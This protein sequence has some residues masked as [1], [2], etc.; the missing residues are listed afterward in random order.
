MRRAKADAAV[1][2]ESAE[3]GEKG[4]IA[5]PDLDHL[6]VTHAVALDAPSGHRLGVFAYSRNRG[7]KWRAFS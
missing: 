6:F 2:P 3:Q 7:E 1:V 5:A 4:A